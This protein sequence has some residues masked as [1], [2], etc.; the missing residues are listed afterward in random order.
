MSI[1]PLTKYE[2]ARLIGQRAK[3]L[4]LGAEPT[5]CT[6]GLLNPIKIAEKEFY[7]GKIPIAILRPLPSGEKIR[8]SILPNS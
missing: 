4:S 5:V 2:K 1:F 7:E 6:K 3:Q 8:V